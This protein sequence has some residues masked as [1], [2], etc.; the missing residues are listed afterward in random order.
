MDT[1]Y[2]SA[3]LRQTMGRRR[4]LTATGALGIGAAFVVA[5]GGG[6][7]GG[8][9]QSGSSLVAKPVDT[10]R[11]VKRGGIMKDRAFADP[12]SLDI[13]TPNNPI[14]P[15]TND[16]YNSLVQFEPGYLKPSENKIMN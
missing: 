10:T 9:S 4:A 5:C 3:S 6:D 11:Q 14:T 7:S 8:G 15:W 13:L 12:S 2:W 16:V 1:N